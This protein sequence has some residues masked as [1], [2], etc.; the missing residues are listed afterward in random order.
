P[1]PVAAPEPAPEPEP[2]P[3]PADIPPAQRPHNA[4]FGAAITF[5]DGS[6]QKGKVVRVERTVDWYGDQGWSDAEGD[7]KLTLEG[8]GTEVDVPWSDIRQID[9]TYGSPTD[10]DCTYDSA[11]EPA[12]YMC[13]LKTTTKVKTKD[14]KVWDGAD[15]HKWL[16]VFESGEA[17][18][19]WIAKLPE[20]QQEA[21][22]PELG[23]VE[24]NTKLYEELQARITKTR[25]GKVPKSITITV[26]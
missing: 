7:L 6:S 5:A 1:V 16:F 15:R 20:R 11:F 25:V 3:A 10:V 18:E 9:I 21:A 24:E 4:D 17:P 23:T 22:V 2:E 19:F 26:P 13:V 14:A 8:G 12:M